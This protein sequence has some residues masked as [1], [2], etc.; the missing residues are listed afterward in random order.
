MFTYTWHD[1]QLLG[2]GGVGGCCKC[3][4]FKCLHSSPQVPTLGVAP[5]DSLQYFRDAIPALGLLGTPH[6]VYSTAPY[7]V[8]DDVQLV[9]KYLRAYKTNKI[10]R[11]YKESECN[12]FA[13]G[14]PYKFGNQFYTSVFKLC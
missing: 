8:D 3:L 11:L 9:C 5:E 12:V 14:V 7:V 6:P 4:L 13:C 2:G 10:N 1:S